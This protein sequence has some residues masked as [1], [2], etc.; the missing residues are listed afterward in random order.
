MCLQ[1]TLVY[2]RGVRSLLANECSSVFIRENSPA[3]RRSRAGKR[4]QEG[5]SEKGCGEGLHFSLLCFALFG[6][7]A[8]DRARAG[9]TPEQEGGESL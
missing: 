2:L 4:V 3:A 7:G 5:S 6:G 1:K 9:W 8:E